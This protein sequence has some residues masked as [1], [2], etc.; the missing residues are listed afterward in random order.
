M[1]ITLK[2]I[3]ENIDFEIVLFLTRMVNKSDDAD[4]LFVGLDIL[5]NNIKQKYK[6]YENIDSIIYTIKRIDDFFNSV[7]AKLDINKDRLDKF[8]KIFMPTN[9]NMAFLAENYTDIMHRYNCSAQT[10]QYTYIIDT[11]MG[12]QG[13]GYQ[14]G[15]GEKIDFID[16]FD[17]FVAKLN[18]LDITA[19]VKWYCLE[20]VLNRDSYMVE[21]QEIIQK[22]K[23]IY[24]EEAKKIEDIIFKY[25]TQLNELLQKINYDEVENYFHLGF[26]KEED[27]SFV[28]SIAL[29]NAVSISYIAGK[30]SITLGIFYHEWQTIFDCVKVDIEECFDVLKNLGEKRKFEIMTIL[31]KT[32]CNGQQ[33]AEK[34]NLTPATISH[35]INQLMKAGMLKLTLGNKSQ[36][37]VHNGCVQKHLKNLLNYFSED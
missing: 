36:Y 37:S 11:A 15:N 18:S 7:Y 8:F 32:P 3:E 28:F 22:T 6:N 10:A 33:L 31:Q 4:N 29:L 25:Y 2:T 12:D 16:N 14:S 27:A 9:I 24:L 1:N 34:L 5:S 26:S 13:C 19:E 21:I 35:H 23:E 20:I 17:D 30:N